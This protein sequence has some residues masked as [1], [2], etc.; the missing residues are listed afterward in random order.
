MA[1][2][3]AELTAAYDKLSEAYEGLPE[4]KRSRE[5]CRAYRREAREA[6]SR[7]ASVELHEAE[8]AERLHEACESTLGGL[9][10]EFLEEVRSAL[11]SREGALRE[12]SGASQPCKGATAVQYEAILQAVSACVCVL[13][14]EN[15][16]LQ[17]HVLAGQR[18]ARGGSESGSSQ[19][20]PAVRRPIDA[21]PPRDLRDLQREVVRLQGENRGLLSERG[22]APRA[23]CR[24]TELEDASH[25]WHQAASEEATLRRSAEKHA[26]HALQAL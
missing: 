25:R 19:G 17:A 12:E 16:E 1:E 2:E 23:G 14:R 8:E 5:E 24:I 10:L 4:L 21:S 26:E 18:E 20:S 15:T 3:L 9:P 11:P 6:S 22:G 7:L 13:L